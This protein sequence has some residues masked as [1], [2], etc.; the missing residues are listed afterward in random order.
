MNFK[1]NNDYDVP[2][3]AMAEKDNISD[4]LYIS[5]DSEEWWD[6]FMQ[7]VT[8]L[9]QKGEAC[10]LSSEIIY[11]IDEYYY[12]I[13]DCADIAVRKAQMDKGQAISDDYDEKSAQ[14]ISSYDM[15]VLQKVEKTF[16]AKIIKYML[17]AAVCMIFSL[18]L[19]ILYWQFSA[20]SGVLLLLSFSFVAS[21]AANGV[22]VFSHF[23]KKQIINGRG[24]HPEK[25]FALFGK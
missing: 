14:L 13:R 23:R 11:P 7:L 9:P 8:R 4:M 17:I 16:T 18:V 22:A 1:L 25:G 24:G 5:G 2:K 6:Y 15:R 12:S 10:R 21:F 19:G 20:P 3:D